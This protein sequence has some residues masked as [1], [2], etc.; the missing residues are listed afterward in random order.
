M[1]RGE[2]IGRLLLFLL[3]HHAVLDIETKQPK[4]I[5]QL[6]LR[7]R[8]GLHVNAEQVRLRQGNFPF[9]SIYK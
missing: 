8:P 3:D 9:L 1:V 2:V 6:L 5:V 7:A 4:L